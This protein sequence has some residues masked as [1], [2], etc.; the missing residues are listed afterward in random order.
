M[1][2]HLEGQ[3]SSNQSLAVLIFDVDFFKHINEYGHSADDPALRLTGKPFEGMMHDGQ[4]VGRWGDDEFIVILYDVG[5][6]LA[7]AIA[8]R[9]QSKVRQ[10]N[11]P[12]F[13]VGA[14]GGA[15]N[16]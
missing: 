1:L 4:R 8:E 9:L 11:G 16:S 5:Q 6:A 14:A 2:A 13:S 15:K 3:P 12:A 7:K 10:G